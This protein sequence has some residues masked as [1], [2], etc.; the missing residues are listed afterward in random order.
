MQNV[1]THDAMTA[2]LSQRAAGANPKKTLGEIGALAL[3]MS[4]LFH[5]I[6]VVA[7]ALKASAA[8][9]IAL[10]TPA[11]GA[12]PIDTDLVDVLHS[13]GDSVVRGSEDKAQ[14]EPDRAPAEKPASRPA[15]PATERTNPKRDATPRVPPAAPPKSDPS[16][17][18]TDEAPTRPPAEHHDA[19]PRTTPIARPPESSADTASPKSRP[20]VDAPSGPTSPA[21]RKGALG[22]PLSEVP[23][24]GGGQKRSGQRDLAASFTRELPDCAY[25]VT[26]WAALPPGE[27]LVLEARIELDASG[28][29][30]S[31]EP[32]DKT[33]PS[34]AFVDTM[35]RV[36]GRLKIGLFALENGTIDG[37][38]L[39]VRVIASVSDVP[40]P[41]RPGGAVA[42][43]HTFD[44]GRGHASFTLESGRRVD[45]MI[46]V[47]KI[48]H[49]S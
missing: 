30:L 48:E 6:L 32:E 21:S 4:L 9:P 35:H 44:K 37:G 28:K 14:G 31:V 2:S 1:S 16:D 26:T 12:D 5:A 41:D 10:N 46:A 8:E 27:S 43:E 25:F 15:E 19:A 45:F 42:L 13:T 17:P 39:H 20:G 29:L 7:T 18:A 11:M 33:T 38:V 24:E 3:V 23:G 47:V 22:G 36:A 34:A 40:A 49:A